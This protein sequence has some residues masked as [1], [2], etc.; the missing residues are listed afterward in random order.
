MRFSENDL[1]QASKAIL[2]LHSCR[3]FSELPSTFISVINSIVPSEVAAYN[4]VDHLKSEI[5]IEHNFNPAE[6]VK[7]LM[8]ALMAHADEHPVNN[9]QKETGEKKALKISDFLN[10]NQFQRLGIYNEFYRPLGIRHQISFYLPAAPGLQ[11]ALTLQRERRDFTEQDRFLLNLLA[12]HCALAY[13]K[14]KAIQVSEAGPTERKNGP[15]Q[16]TLQCGADG[17]ILSAPPEISRRMTAEFKQTSTLLPAQIMEWLRAQ[18]V[19]RTD[20]SEPTPLNIK[21]GTGT[22]RFSLQ[23][24]GAPTLIIHVIVQNAVGGEPINS[25]GLTPRERQVLHWVAAGKTNPEIAIILGTKTRT[26]HKH[27]ERIL[28]KLRVENRLAAAV[29]VNHHSTVRGFCDF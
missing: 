4:E 29:L 5:R 26:I 12:P 9:F 10:S 15:R 6:D 13:A 19:S 8:P 20:L 21:T 14:T 24:P 1:V 16:F 17:R 7:K 23:N 22:W 2:Q 27:V 18:N 3:N 25:L 11:I 28:A